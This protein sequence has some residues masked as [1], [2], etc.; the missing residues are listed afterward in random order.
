MVRRR[1]TVRFR[2]GALDQDDNSNASNSA[3]GHSGGQVNVLRPY[4]QMLAG[5]SSS[6][7]APLGAVR[8][9]PLRCPVRGKPSR[10]SAGRFAA[11]SVLTV[12]SCLERAI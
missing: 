10:A 9:L 12:C 6:A 11:R 7:L 3:G 4:A 1:S 5:S 2:N 8:C